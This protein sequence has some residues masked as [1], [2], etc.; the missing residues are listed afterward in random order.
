MGTLKRLGYKLGLV[1][2]GFNYFADYLKEK[3]GLD[4]AFANQLEIKDGALTGK[5]LGKIVDNT[6]KAKIVNMVST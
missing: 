2:G 4:F 6:Y 5:V 3:L 1:S